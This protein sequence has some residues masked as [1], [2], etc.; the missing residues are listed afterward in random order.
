MAESK[1]L[2]IKSKMNKDLDDR[3][4]PNGEYR[5]ATNVMI[6]R[7]DGADVGAVENVL[8]NQLKIKPPVD[9][10]GGTRFTAPDLS[11]IGWCKDETRNL[12]YLFWTNYNDNSANSIANIDTTVGYH[13]ISQYN[14][15]TASHII[16]VKGAFLNFSKS[17]PVIGVNLI[18]NLLYWTD[19]RNQPRK[20]NITRS[21]ESID[22]ATGI[23]NYYNN[24]DHISVTKYYPF[25]TIKLW[26][27]E[28]IP[29]IQ[30]QMKSKSIQY[31]PFN[32]NES[33][34]ANAN[35]TYDATYAG[36]PDFMKDK[37]IRFSYR[38]KFDDNEYSLSAPFTQIGFIPFQDGF[39]TSYSNDDW[40]TKKTD[41]EDA[42]QST[43]TK[44]M[45]NKVDSVNLTIPLPSTVANLRNNYK[46]KEIDVLYKESNSTNIRVIETLDVL[47]LQNSAT[48]AVDD[49]VEYEYLAKKSI[50]ILPENQ[51]TRVSDQSPIRALAQETSG[52]RVIYGNFV[53]RYPYPEKIDYKVGVSEKFVTNTT[54]S[55]SNPLPEVT[56]VAYP[57]HT[58][59]RNRTYQV[60]IVLSDRYGRQSPVILN[61]EV[62]SEIQGGVEYGSSTI[63]HE[64]GGDPYGTTPYWGPYLG[65]STLRWTG[66]SLKLLFN[67]KIEV[68]GLP[69]NGLYDAVKNPLG[70][71]SY[72]VVVQQ[73]QQEYYNV[74]LP[75]ILNGY[76]I[77]GEEQYDDEVAHVVL[78]GDNINKVPRDLEEV[79]PEQKLFRSSV[80]LYGRVVNEPAINWAFLNLPSSSWN[81]TYNIQYYPQAAPPPSSGVAQAPVFEDYH[82]A[83]QIGTFEDL[84]F[85][86]YIGLS[87]SVVGDTT[88]GVGSTEQQFTITYT[89]PATAAN[90]QSYIYTKD[91]VKEIKPGMRVS[92]PDQDTFPVANFSVND[93]NVIVVSNSK[94]PNYDP[95]GATKDLTGEGRVLV[96]YAAIDTALA[97]PITTCDISIET[98]LFF[99]YSNLYEAQS[100]PLIARIKTKKAIGTSLYQAAAPTITAGGNPPLPLTPFLAVY[101]TAPTES[102]LDIFWET[103]TSGLISDLNTA[104]DTGLTVADNIQ[105][106]FDFKE[107]DDIGTDLAGTIAATDPTNTPINGWA[108]SLVDVQSFDQ[109]G[110]IIS[111]LN[112]FNFT[113]T[114]APGAGTVGEYELTNAI[115]LAYDVPALNDFTENYSFFFECTDVTGAY[116]GT[117]QFVKNG[118]LSNIAPLITPS[119]PN[120][121]QVLTNVT[122]IVQLTGENG[123]F[124]GVGSNL[125]TYTKD[126]VWEIINQEKVLNPGILINTFALSDNNGTLSSYE[127]LLIALNPNGGNPTQ[128]SNDV[129]APNPNNITALEAATDY[130]I[131]VRLYD[132][133]D[134]TNYGGAAFDDYVVRV[135][136]LAAPLNIGA[137]TENYRYLEGGTLFFGDLAPAIT[138]WNGG[139]YETMYSITYPGLGNHPA[140]QGHTGPQSSTDPEPFSGFSDDGN[141][142]VQL[143]P[144]PVLGAGNYNPWSRSHWGWTGNW[145]A[146]PG[147]KYMG[148]NVTPVS[149]WTP[150]INTSRLIERAEQG[151]AKV[152]DTS[153]C[154]NDLGTG[155]DHY[156]PQHNIEWGMYGAT[157]NCKIGGQN[158]ISAARTTVSSSGN[159]DE[160]TTDREVTLTTGVSPGVGGYPLASG[161]MPIS[162]PKG[163]T[164]WW[165]YGNS[166]QYTLNLGTGAQDWQWTEVPFKFIVN[167]NSWPTLPAAGDQASV[168]KFVNDGP[169][170]WTNSEGRDGVY[171]L[172]QGYFMVNTN[173]T[174]QDGVDTTKT[175][176]FMSVTIGTVAFGTLDSN[177]YSSEE[178]WSNYGKGSFWQSHVLQVRQDATSP[179]Q[180][181]FDSNLNSFKGGQ[182]DMVGYSP[183]GVA[184]SYLYNTSSG[185]L[186]RNREMTV[187]GSGYATRFNRFDV[188]VGQNWVQGR[189]YWR[190]DGFYFDPETRGF[191][192]QKRITSP[193]GGNALNND[194]KLE[195]VRYQVN[196]GIGAVSDEGRYGV[197]LTTEPD[198]YSVSP[199]NAPYKGNVLGGYTLFPYLGLKNGDDTS[200]AASDFE[201]GPASG[202]AV[203][204]TAADPLSMNLGVT[205]D[206]STATYNSYYDKPLMEGFMTCRFLQG[207]P[208]RNPSLLNTIGLKPAYFE[209]TILI[210][211]NTNGELRIISGNLRRGARK[212][213]NTE[214]NDGVYNTT[215]NNLTQD[216]SNDNEGKM[217]NAFSKV[218]ALR[219]KT[220]FTPKDTMG[221][222]QSYTRV[223][224]KDFYYSQ[225]DGTGASGGPYFTF[226][227][228]L[229]YTQAATDPRDFQTDYTSQDIGSVSNDW[230]DGRY[231]FADPDM[232]PFQ[233]TSGALAPNWK[234]Q[235]AKEP[236]FQYVKQ[237][238]S[239]DELAGSLQFDPISIADGWYIYT[240]PR[241]AFDVDVRIQGNMVSN[242]QYPA[243]DPTNVNGLL[244]PAG[245]PIA[246]NPNTG[247]RVVGYPFGSWCAFGPKKYFPTAAEF[248]GQATEAGVWPMWLCRIEGGAVVQNNTPHP[249]IREVND[250]PQPW[251]VKMDW[252]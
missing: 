72:K 64:Y 129:T 49:F 33:P 218:Y 185:V 95:T 190:G 42:Y 119:V 173:R 196:R 187:E 66:D 178:N 224:V 96:K 131:T 50:N 247:N 116:P 7:S 228:Y 213:D 34:T 171:M 233:K 125:S 127:K 198:A 122:S 20:I 25:E 197:W 160:I 143:V 217:Q 74:Y 103:S 238:W 68:P 145:A 241:P 243:Y 100:N 75:G 112:D 246:G 32:P 153:P 150:P 9:F 115:H 208:A 10:I 181:I 13:Y 51:T 69:N 245:Y 123:S 48:A 192:E 142:N 239:V 37:F 130:D 151:E 194:N 110:A 113:Q 216:S 108:I 86:D 237:W 90:T 89:A 73:T 232:V 199:I 180:T 70:W 91:Y 92:C 62:E 220:F 172:P 147:N 39:F 207:V 212:V 40:D 117:L 12:I 169:L 195:S 71:Y 174:W 159:I 234:N 82:L 155:I 128:T 141:V 222:V 1:N 44:L 83:T 203:D 168:V 209:K 58:L 202:N 35:P 204:K 157:W 179:W 54:I 193:G 2:F 235:Y 134:P 55:P 200:L 146:F 126:L 101:E 84:G 136:T 144:T 52:N 214:W 133:S 27:D 28:G 94:N 227:Q 57:N 139:V 26:K 225:P 85:G 124:D 22:P 161:T 215:I 107:N 105:W 114:Q 81:A 163:P 186:Y 158:L 162:G 210:D 121:V 137:K 229:F 236:G 18:E 77:W 76:P 188:G 189:D 88:T 23:S 219:D 45:E 135:S 230:N 79:G 80:Q 43:I 120:P 106:D 175:E 56:R 118:A 206:F 166:N 184:G 248:P 252:I 156:T 182:W 231:Y 3:L 41:E 249:Y 183:S 226:Y 132:A 15:N 240:Q 98:P 11:I 109:T 38:F 244:A 154:S 61:G 201:M 149:T 30:A 63:T 99:S 31:N 19:N 191:N 164:W 167:S 104:I 5:D 8:G 211:K 93:L 138:D 223:R 250:C 176:G 67:S 29:G 170:T 221:E 251:A 36:D 4:V 148:S 165:G 17:S 21:E 47:E 242:S 177:D 65:T 97:P 140:F 59:K 53:N 102:N 78:L 24:E 46:I 111:R 205:K 14:I 60:G 6:S 87:V 16:L 152:S